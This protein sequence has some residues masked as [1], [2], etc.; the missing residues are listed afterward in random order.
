MS[1]DGLLITRHILKTMSV[2]RTDHPLR[3]VRKYE[4]KWRL[5]DHQGMWYSLC[6]PTPP[7]EFL[8]IIEAS[9]PLTHTVLQAH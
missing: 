5:F 7:H 9:G 2:S 6:S 3:A 1:L 8:A 4:G